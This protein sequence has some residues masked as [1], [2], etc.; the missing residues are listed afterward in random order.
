MEQKGNYFII[1]YKTLCGM[2]LVGNAYITI[3]QII[4]N[5]LPKIMDMLKMVCTVKP[6][7]IDEQ[8]VCKKTGLEIASLQCHLNFDIYR[9]VA[10]W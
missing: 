4:L 1:L 9:L 2:R 8:T 3:M 10:R 6:S 5:M 7:I